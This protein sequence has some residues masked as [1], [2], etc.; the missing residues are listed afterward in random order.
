MLMKH[1]LRVRLTGP[2]HS[3]DQFHWPKHV[4]RCTLDKE[5]K[6][7][8]GEREGRYGMAM[9]RLKSLAIEHFRGI[10]KGRIDDFADVNI[11]VGRNNS[12]KTTVVEA[13]ARVGTSGGLQQDL[14]GRPVEP[15]WQ[16]VRSAVPNHGGFGGF[17]GGGGAVVQPDPSLLWYRQDSSKELVLTGTLQEIGDKA[18]SFNLVYSRIDDSHTTGRRRGAAIRKIQLESPA[19]DAQA[20]HAFCAGMTVFRPQDAF[21]A[22]IEQQFWPKLLSNR[23]DRL[24]TQ[25]LN[26]VF[27]LE[28]ESFQI[29]GNSQ[30]LVLFDD[31][32]IPLDS[33]GDGT[34]AAMRTLMSLLMLNGTLFMLEEPEC[35]QHPGSLERFAASLSK[36]A[37]KQSVQLIISTHS[38]E[39][40]RS[41]LIGAKAADSAAAVF[42]LTLND[43]KQDARRLDPEAVDSL[44]TTGVDVRF[45]DLYA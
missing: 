23:R 17:T 22:A 12:G 8:D 5:E 45:L 2:V 28:A 33:Q 26:D 31:Y 34:R 41:F 20:R 25:V 16:Q 44:T 1:L 11:L 38:S 21:N 9:I 35:H 10:R 15:F 30:L 4:R 7:A 18:T 14:F 13:I 24:L 40:V 3:H 32:S 6:S 42:H 39:C 19:G 27:G 36:L 37:K 43:G 29:V